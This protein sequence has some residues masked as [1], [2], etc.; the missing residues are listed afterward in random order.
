MHA[1]VGTLD[2]SLRII[3]GLLLV[4]LALSGIAGPWAWIGLLPLATGVLAWCPLYLPRGRSTVVRTE[5]H[6]STE[7]LRDAIA[8]HAHGTVR[9]RTLPARHSSRA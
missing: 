1:N 5:H 2:R 9:P 7:A 6:L 8:L 3:A 4:D